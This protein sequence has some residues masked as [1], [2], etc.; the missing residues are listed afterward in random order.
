VETIPMMTKGTPPGPPWTAAVIE[1]GANAVRLDVAQIDRE[2]RIETLEQARRPVRFGHDAF[3][4]WKLGKPTMN[5]GISALRD[6]TKVLE[7]YRCDPVRA[8][9]KSAV[10]EAQNADSFLDRVTMAVNLEVELLEPVEE[11]RLTIAALL[12]AEGEALGLGGRRALVAEVGGGTAELTVLDGGKVERSENFALGSVRMRE[13]LGIAQEPPAKAEQL[14]R[15]HVANGLDV[16]RRS[17]PLSDVAL[18]VALGPDATFAA[19]LAGGEG[20]GAG[21]CRIEAGAFG[22]ILRG[23]AGQTPEALAR[24][25]GLSQTDAE[26]LV[27]ALLVHQ[28]LLEA[29]GA[30][31]IAVSPVSLR[32]GLL[33]DIART[34]TGQEDRTRD[35]AVLQSARAIGEKYRADRKHSEHVAGLALR[36]FDGLKKLH[37]LDARARLLLQAAGLLHDTGFY[38]GAS[39]HHKHSYYLILNS[40]IVGLRREEVQVV[41]HVSR[42]HRRS[43][44]NKSHLEYTALPRDRRVLVNK[45]AALLRVA[46]AL[47]RDHLQ[48]VREF[49][50]EETHEEVVL[51][52]RGTGELD[53]DRKAVSRK[54]DLFEETF[55]LKVRVEGEA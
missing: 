16:I 51:H 38:I 20:S 3:T 4:Q 26:T 14:L 44:P 22:R 43:M 55:G 54:A 48:K 36:L 15:R 35:E 21:A 11:T 46:D 1:I 49:E 6:F 5:A 50:I 12:R 18:Q 8:V 32:D 39:A 10:R 33:L 28:A 52:A 2:G 37:G 31:E 45:L 27:P 7:T 42:Y 13:I 47:D 25:H 53:L 30:K 19:R 9:A 40:P 41:A 17:L 29:T 34:L 23:L 24:K